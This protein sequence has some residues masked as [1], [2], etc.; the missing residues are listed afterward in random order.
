MSQQSQAATASVSEQLIG[1]VTRNPEGLLL[2]AAG[3]ALLMRKSASAFGASGNGLQRAPGV[4][5]LKKAASG[6]KDYAS[7]MAERTR[8]TVGSVASSA[9]DYAGEARRA[10]GE[11]SERVIQNAQSAVQGT[12]ERV[13]QDQ[14]LMIAVAGLA[15]GVAV[16]TAFP[17]TDFEKETLGPVGEQVSDAASRVGDQLK[18]A[19][20]K[21]RDTLKSAAEERGLNGE[22][23]KEVATEVAQSF[24]STMKG[25]SANAPRGPAG[26][27]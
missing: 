27:Q 25:E 17:A 3:A 8:E 13:L 20:F 21:A 19:A 7:D 22:G 11:Q 1:A 6:A 5:A 23:L 18:E 9:S 15:A 2:L 12:I 24:G 4:D 16:A 14:P 26:G 10:V